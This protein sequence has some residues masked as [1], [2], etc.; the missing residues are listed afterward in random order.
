MLFCIASG[1]NWH[2]SGLR[3]MMARQLLIRG[4]MDREAA[5]SYVLTGQGRAVLERLMMQAGT[6]G[7]F[8]C[9]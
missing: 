2:N 1:T 4:L 6:R 8:H 3:H 9:G 5:G 7:Y